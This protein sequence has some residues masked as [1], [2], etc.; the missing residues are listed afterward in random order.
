MTIETK[1]EVSKSLIKDYE[2]ELQRINNSILTTEREKRHASSMSTIGISQMGISSLRPI[3][4]YN[5]V[6]NSTRASSLNSKL[7]RL[8]SEKSIVESKLR[9]ER[10]NLVELESELEYS[11]R[12]EAKLIVDNGK[13]YVEGDNSKTNILYSLNNEI[14][15]YTAN[16]NLIME[17]QQ[18]KKYV[19]LKEELENIVKS[20][21][22]PKAEHSLLHRL[23][24]Y[25]SNYDFNFDYVVIDGK[26]LVDKDFI[27]PAISS[28]NAYIKLYEDYIERNKARYDKFQPNVFGKVFKLAREKQKAEWD[29][30][31]L[32]KENEYKARIQKF[33]DQIKSY[34][35][36]KQEFIDP[37]KPA[38][39]TFSELR[40][41][42]ED[43]GFVKS[44]IADSEKFKE[45]IENS[46]IL[47]SQGIKN[48]SDKII[49][50]VKF[51]LDKNNLKVTPENVYKIIFN[52]PEFDYLAKE[53]ENAL[54]YK[55]IQKETSKQTLKETTA[56]FSDGPSL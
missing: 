30:S 44:Y 24:C 28:T 7:S 34:E 54:G 1:I 48:I 16:Y 36:I 39:D 18:V 53:I 42:V 9:T 31:V 50:S 8:R 41:L 49:S 10:Q 33:D 35:K 47:K 23:E 26:V 4:T 38:L 11:K 12:P 56:P 19:E 43:S 40:Q 17:S 29:K 51:Y 52:N 25:K 22:L 2:S 37:A 46:T 21:N 45:N 55:P 13:I 15:Y 20:L 14:T 5:Y 3:G 6:S 27:S 32:E